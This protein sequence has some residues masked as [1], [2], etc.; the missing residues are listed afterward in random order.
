MRASE[1]VDPADFRGAIDR[2][3]RRTK[4]NLLFVAVVSLFA[5]SLV[6]AVPIY[7]FQISDRVLT[8][9]STDTLLMLSSIVIGLILAHVLLDLLRRFL[10]TRI[11]VDIEVSLGAP[12]LGAA[13]RANSSSNTR[14]FQALNDLQQLRSFLT[15]PVL[16]A[17]MDAPVAPV[18][19]AVVFMVH[20]H[21]GIIVTTTILV[22]L[23]LAK[24]NQRVTAGPFALAHSFS[25]RASMQTEAMARNA[26]VINAMGMIPEAVAFWGKETSI[27]LKAQLL[28]QDRNV[29]VSSLSK[30]ARLSTQ[31]VMLGWGAYLALHD[32]LTGGMIIAASIIA[33]RALA[34]VEGTIEGWKSLVAARSA[35]GRV[36]NLLQNSPLNVHRL[37]L[38]APKGNLVVERLLFV[39]PPDKKVV[40]NGIS[41]SLSAGESLAVVGSSGSGKTTLGKML[42][43]SLVPT[44]GHVRLDGMDLRNWD[45]R[46][47]GECIGYLP[48]DLQLF[49]GSIKQNIARMRESI[50]EENIFA[51]AEIAN[52]HGLV[53]TFAQGYETQVAMDGT[54]LS[55]GQRQRIGLARA[56]Y[57]QPKLVVL[58]EPNSNLDGKGE[59]ALAHAIQT[60]KQ[61]KIT[62]V[63]ITQRPALLKS[64]DRI[65]LVENGCAPL[66]GTREEVL[67]KLFGRT[68]TLP[69]RGHSETSVGE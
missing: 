3:V 54:P 50:I 34:P 51:A 66:F 32:Q 20:P 40:L 29:I 46:Q 38:P 68:Q 2:V 25:T 63:A 57:G 4:A 67:P 39:P 33:G 43:A 44:A 6:L 49:P 30:F 64:V 52:I 10:L 28:G 14:E 12:V 41:F 47:L 24:I 36:R 22:L 19:L 23:L 17:V 61:R 27:A 5:S 1:K 11:A 37:Q 65:L 21:L 9:R 13:A 56:F 48:Q 60:A 53:S 59:A 26:Q 55:A 15:G 31:I 42:V 8:S 58:D 45:S 35:Y 62:V 16:L 69:A 7:L 18:Y